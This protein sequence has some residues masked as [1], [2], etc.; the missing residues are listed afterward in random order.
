ML[1]VFVQEDKSSIY[2]WFNYFVVKNYY[3]I[4]GCINPPWIMSFYNDEKF[5][6]VKCINIYG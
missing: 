2:N 3:T 4:F 5:N 1:P 6:G